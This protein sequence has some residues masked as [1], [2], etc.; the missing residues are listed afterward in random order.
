MAWG[1]STDKNTYG[2]IFLFDTEGKIKTGNCQN[3]NET[4]KLSEQNNWI[5]KFLS[6]LP[7]H[8]GILHCNIAKLDWKEQQLWLK[9]LPHKAF[10]SIILSLFPPKQFHMHSAQIITLFGS[11]LL[12]ENAFTG[13]SESTSNQQKLPSSRIWLLLRF[14]TTQN[15]NKKQSVSFITFLY[16]IITSPSWKQYTF[17]WKLRN[18]TR[19]ATII[20]WAAYWMVM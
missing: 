5:C 20:V 14:F 18:E 19:I 11:G 7:I 6:K 15:V 2:I 16:L 4:C 13:F 9:S 1:E 8:V 10:L 12:N 17:G 3:T